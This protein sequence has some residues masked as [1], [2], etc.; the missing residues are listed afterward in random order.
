M[1]GG[2]ILFHGGDHYSDQCIVMRLMVPPPAS[3]LKNE[4]SV[5]F[6]SP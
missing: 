5:D 4:G 6:T 1:G 3:Y 2:V